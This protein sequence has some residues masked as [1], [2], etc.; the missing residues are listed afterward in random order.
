MCTGVE[1]FFVDSKKWSHV[2]GDIFRFSARNIKFSLKTIKLAR[3]LSYLAETEDLGSSRDALQTLSTDFF[4]RFACVRTVRSKIGLSISERKNI[5][6]IALKVPNVVR[7]SETL[8]KT[9]FVISTESECACCPIE[10]ISG[11]F[12]ICELLANHECW[13]ILKGALNSVSESLTTVWDL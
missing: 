8:C 2:T 7:L 3:D 10:Q 4:V 11:N 9:L 5:E 6:N 12:R 1:N 13:N